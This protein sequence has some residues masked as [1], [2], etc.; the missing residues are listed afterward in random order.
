[1]QRRAFMKG[2][3]ALGASGVIFPH[4]SIL[5]A[6]EA[7]SKKRVFHVKNSYNLQH[8]NVNGFT[9]LWVPL[10]LESSYQKVSD[11][12]F[13]SNATRAFVT[14]KNTYKARTLYTQ[15]KEGGEKLLEVSYTITTYE[16]T[17]DLSKAKSSTKYP[18]EV[19]RY[20]KPT[21]HIPTTGKVRALALQITQNAKTPL[22]KAKAIYMWVTE[23]MYR[24]NSV[25]GC[26]VGDAG[27][28]IEENILGGKCTDISSV[29]V[30]LLRSVSVPCR[31]MF[32]IRL[33]SSRFSKAC[34][35]SDENGLAKITG[36]EHCRAEFYINGCGWVPCD[37]ADV[38]K[39]ILAE[40]LTLNDPLVKEVRA[41]FFGNWEMNWMGY[42]TGRDFILEPK[43]SQIPLNMFGYPY[44][45]VE[46]EV[47]DYYA[48]ASFCYSFLSQEKF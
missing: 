15:W 4:V 42:N 41:Y 45:E 40:K 43:P 14:D 22:E 31:E 36:A 47:L 37:P 23:N 7:K 33:G 1:M 24:D 29:F 17:V 6:S 11:F 12:K 21:A 48:P 9:K 39:V 3:V 8:E 10:P 30:A 32:G 16:R 5:E 18:K 20:L 34:G 38:T 2:C 46:D 28:A 25:I 13:N 19:A 44:A 35:S 26:G 27:K